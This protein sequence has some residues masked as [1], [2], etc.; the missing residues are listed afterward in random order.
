MIIYLAIWV[1]MYIHTARP[2][3]LTFKSVDYKSPKQSASTR[4]YPQL[5]SPKVVFCEVLSTTI[6]ALSGIRWLEVIRKFVWSHDCT[7]FS[8]A[9]CLWL[10]H[11]FFSEPYARKLPVPLRSLRLMCKFPGQMLQ[12]GEVRFCKFWLLCLL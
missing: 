3:H 4:M 6:S 11:K 9:R 2:G 10:V 5:L 1:R 8:T 7:A 12:L